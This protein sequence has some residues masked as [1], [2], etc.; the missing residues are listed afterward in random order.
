MEISKENIP[1]I[2]VNNP[3]N[4]CRAVWDGKAGTDAGAEALNVTVLA[5]G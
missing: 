5:T 2:L 3:F 1:L 4:M